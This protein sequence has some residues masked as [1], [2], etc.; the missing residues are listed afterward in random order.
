[1][2]GSSYQLSNFP[3]SSWLKHLTAH[4]ESW[5]GDTDHS[6]ILWTAWEN[7]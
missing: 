2:L 1:M 6:I 3:T 5:N 4:D 7:A